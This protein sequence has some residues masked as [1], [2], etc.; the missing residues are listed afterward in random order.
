[1]R[2][3][4]QTLKSRVSPT[5]FYAFELP[6]MPKPGRGSSWVSGGLC[7]F[8][9]DR[10]AGSFRINLD[11]GAYRCFACGASG[12]DIVAFVMQRYSL[13]FRD[14]VRQLYQDW[15]YS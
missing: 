12:G 14:A 10:H 3:N 15:R 7:P 8:H 9:K 6:N 5:E 4:A 1:M 13:P 11:T 2:P